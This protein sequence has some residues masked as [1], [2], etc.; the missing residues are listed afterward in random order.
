MTSKEKYK[1]S[2]IRRISEVFEVFIEGQENERF[3]STG[4]D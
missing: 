2:F 1:D 3:Q 4:S